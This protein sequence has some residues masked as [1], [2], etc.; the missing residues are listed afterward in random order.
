MVRT[1]ARIGVGGDTQVQRTLQ[2]ALRA[3]KH[4][5]HAVNLLDN[6]GADSQR[7]FLVK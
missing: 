5:A 3:D 1:E 7:D 6:R 4:A 2:K